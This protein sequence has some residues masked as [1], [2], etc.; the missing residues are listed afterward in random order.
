MAIFNSSKPNQSTFSKPILIVFL[1]I[2]AVVGYFIFRIFAA[3][4]PNVLNATDMKLPSGA[5]TQNGAVVINQKAKAKDAVL[6]G[7]IVAAGAPRTITVSASSSGC[8]NQLPTIQVH[9]TGQGVDNLYGSSVGANG[10]YKNGIS[11]LADS[12]QYAVT[13]KYHLPTVQGCTLYLNSVTLTVPKPTAKA[14]AATRVTATTAVLNGQVDAK[15]TKSTFHFEYGTDT[16]YGKPTNDSDVK[17]IGT[18]QA[19]SQQVTGLLPNSTYHYRIAVN[20]IGGTGYSNDMVFT[21]GNSSSAGSLTVTAAATSQI[22]KNGAMLAGTINDNNDAAKY[23]FQYSSA[24]GSFVK[25]PPGSTSLAAKNGSQT[26]QRHLGNLV[27]NKTYSWQLCASFAN[28][29]GLTCS[30]AQSFTTKK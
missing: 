4:T 10:S 16:N 17:T 30:D 28:G 7:N 14:S 3:G 11:G 27:H 18:A 22:D 23:Y 6:S 15:G 13:I 19:V 21:T 24:G 12:R 26:V 1:L 20:S 25:V 9:L 8:T 2:F 29:T 5:T